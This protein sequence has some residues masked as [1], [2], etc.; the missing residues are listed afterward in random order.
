MRIHVFGCTCT[1]GK[2][3]IQQ[4]TM[5][6]HQVSCSSRSNHC[7]L[8]NH[9]QVDNLNVS[10]LSYLSVESLDAIIIAAS[11]VPIPEH[12]HDWHN[13]VEA[14]VEGLRNI[15]RWSSGFRPVIVLMSS[16]SVYGTPP[17]LDGLTEE[18]N[19]SASSPYGI[20]KLYQ[21]YVTR[22]FCDEHSIRFLILRLGYVS[23]KRIHPARLLAKVASAVAQNKRLEVQVSDRYTMNI[24][25]ANAIGEAVCQLLP[26]SS[27]AYNLAGKVPYTLNEIVNALETVSGNKPN[28]Q[29]GNLVVC[30]TRIDSSKYYNEF[31]QIRHTSSLEIALNL[32]HGIKCT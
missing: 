10:D 15:L 18:C 9:I 6:G 24:I 25:D 8:S 5:H 3:L 27:G 30:P 14:N 32:L 28:I 17:S 23:G 26:S 2:E 22:L 16:S 12:V 11:F 7:G 29:Y 20:T 13:L 31:P 1:F 4:I 19:L 21:E